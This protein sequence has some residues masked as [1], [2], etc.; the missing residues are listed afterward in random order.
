MKFGVI[1]RSIGE[2][3]EK[4]CFESVEQYV[5]QSNIHIVKN[6]YPS[7]NAFIEMFRL[8]K[9]NQYDWYLGLDADVIL[10][11]NWFDKFNVLLTKINTDK[12]FRIQFYLK[13]NISEQAIVRGNNFYHGKYTDYALK[14]MKYF[15]LLSKIGFLASILRINKGY[16]YK[17]ESSLRGI[18]KTNHNFECYIDK[19]TIGFHGF[20]QYYYEIFRQYFVR[21]KRN[22]EYSNKKHFNFLSFKK[23]NE[24][25]ANNDL[26]KYVANIGWNISKKYPINNIDARKISIFSNILENNYGIC[27]RRKN[28]LNV[29]DFYSIYDKI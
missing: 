9:I 11:R 6:R 21:R 17:P 1:I 27:E 12:L 18:L 8:A 19:S 26:E 22:P 20:E 7:Y 13:D 2:R 25:L 16:I 5:N 23:Q 3:T 28:D 15:A 4:L 14:Y 10:A 29:K 24:L